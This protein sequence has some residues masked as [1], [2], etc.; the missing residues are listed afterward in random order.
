VFGWEGLAPLSLYQNS[1]IDIPNDVQRI[2]EIK[3]LIAEGYLNRILISQDICY[4]TWRACYG[5][6]GYSHIMKYIIP[7]M[8]R[9]GITKDQIKTM[10]VDNPKRLLTL[11]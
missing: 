3:S 11:Q 7:L 5:G 10:T 1:D 8:L 9:K 6:P 2:F 4:K